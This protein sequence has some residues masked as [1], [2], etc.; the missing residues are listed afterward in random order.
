[1]FVREYG[2]GASTIIVL[3]GGPAAA[4]DVAPLARELGQHWHVLEPF[5]RGSGAEPLTVSTHIRDLD[6]L[7]LRGGRDTR[8][9]IVGHSWGAMLALAYAAV[10]PDTPLALMLIGCGTFSATAR[11]VFEARLEAR[12]TP[13]HRARLKHINETETHEGRRLAMV[14]RVLTDAYAVDA[15][16]GLTYETLDARAYH[17][18]WND[19]VRLQDE[20]VYPAA[21]AAINSPVFM[22]HGADDPHPG[23]LTRDELRAFIPQLEFREIAN[24]GHS[25]W[26]ERKARQNFYEVLTSW[27]RVQFRTGVRG[28]GRS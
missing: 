7:I 21:F 24:C 4:G 9:A 16:E 14:G 18:T 3:H 2:G 26:L 25:P 22:L 6:D 8:L 28:V 15:D 12:L 10:H 20:G 17:E 13:L 19:M 11:T 5:Q 23:E 1:V 27:L